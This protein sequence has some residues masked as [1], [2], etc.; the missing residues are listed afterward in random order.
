MIL[1]FLAGNADHDPAQGSFNRLNREHWHWWPASHKFHTA[2]EF[3]DQAPEFAVVLGCPALPPD[4][5]ERDR[6]GLS[7]P[8][9]GQPSTSNPFSQTVGVPFGGTSGNDPSRHLQVPQWPRWL[10]ARTWDNAAPL[11]LLARPVQRWVVSAV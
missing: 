1:L 5:E 3:N 10:W 2:P 6:V 11:R 8:A 9:F 7:G 4:K